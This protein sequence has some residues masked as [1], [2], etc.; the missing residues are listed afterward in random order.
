MMLVTNGNKHNYKTLIYIP[1]ITIKFFESVVE[2][3]E[4]E[5]FLHDIIRFK[6]KIVCMMFMRRIIVA[7]MQT[8]RVVLNSNL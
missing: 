1:W 8:T 7:S 6:M 5:A 2:I 4:F 3:N